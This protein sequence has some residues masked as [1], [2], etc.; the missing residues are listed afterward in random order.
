MIQNNLKTISTIPLILFLAMIV[1]IL[2]SI[3]ENISIKNLFDALVSEE[4]RFSVALSVKCSIIAIILALLIGVPSGYALARYN[5]KGKEII[6]SLINLPILLPPLVLGFGLLL[7]LGNN[8]TGQFINNILD[9]VFTQN[10]IILA[11]FVIA[12]PFIIRTTR[13][14]FESIDVKYEYVAQSLG[15]SRSE[16][17]LKITLPMA[18]S[19]ILAGAILGWARAIGEFGATLM[20]AGAT[21]MKTETLPIAIFLNVSIGNIDLALAIAVVHIIIAVLIISLMKFVIN[22]NGERYG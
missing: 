7:F 12:T 17:F 9:L 19:G 13:A 2:I 10:G 6:D 14:V 5:F 18:K 21:K 16:S 20:I 15:L 22:L 3:L 11:Q 8:C 4:V 1:C